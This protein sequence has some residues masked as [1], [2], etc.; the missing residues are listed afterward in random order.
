[1]TYPVEI[2]IDN[3]DHVI[4]AGMFAEVDVVRDEVQDS[5]L[6]PKRAV[7]SNNIVYVVE[8]DHVRAVTVETGMSDDENIEITSGLNAGDT[9]VTAGA[10]LLSDGA[11]VHVVNSGAAE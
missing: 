1:M 3:P 9:V 10:Y 4:M 2:T 8:G 5:L 7:D 6:V 11:K